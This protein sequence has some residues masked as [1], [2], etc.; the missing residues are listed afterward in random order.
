MSGGA[1]VED[2]IPRALLPVAFRGLLLLQRSQCLDQ[3]DRI[4][5]PSGSCD[6]SLRSPSSQSSVATAVCRHCEAVDHIIPRK[7]GRIL[8]QEALHKRIADYS[9][10]RPPREPCENSP[11]VAKRYNICQRST[12]SFRIQTVKLALM[13]LASY[14]LFSQRASSVLCPSR[15]RGSPGDTG[16]CLLFVEICR[17]HR[18]HRQCPEAG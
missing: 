5:T 14:S 11:H 18:G 13:I 1:Q 6:L 7:I 4:R 9:S 15:D 8:T 12:F 16:G 2:C 17:I 10:N 3:S